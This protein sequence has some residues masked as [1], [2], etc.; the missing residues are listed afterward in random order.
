M[1]RIGYLLVSVSAVLAV[2][3]GASAVPSAVRAQEKVSG[4]VNAMSFH[5]MPEGLPIL[6]RPLDDSAENLV[7]RNDMEQA[8]TAAGFTV[9]KDG[10]AIVLS[11]ETRR[12]LGGGPTPTR[13]ITKQFVE[14]HEQSD[15]VDR[16]YTPQIGKSS[17]KGSSSVSASRFRLDATLDDKQSGKRLWRGW[18]IARMH[19]DETKNLA[20]AMVPVLVDSLGETVREQTFDIPVG[21]ASET[22]IR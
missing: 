17:P 21:T 19:G 11:F 7:I 15:I 20:K 3:G 12:E 22:T 9:A 5:S 16:R 10:S 14:R 1:G 8:L 18:T 2:L 4:V 13:Q 6:V